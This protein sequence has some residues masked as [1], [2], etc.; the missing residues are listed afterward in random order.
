MN[1]R[2]FLVMIA[3]TVTSSIGVSQYAVYAAMGQPLHEI[4]EAAEDMRAAAESMQTSQTLGGLGV[5]TLTVG[6]SATSMAPANHRTPASIYIENTSTTC[7]Q[8]ASA[9]VAITNG[10]SIG[11][12]C[13][14]GKFWAPEVAEAFCIA[15]S[16][17]ADV[18]VTYGYR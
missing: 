18:D 12:G 8:C 16:A 4:R 2:I 6:T 15:A 14:K 17:V 9:D 1:L 3:I 10:V 5:R 11:D 13:A 7:I